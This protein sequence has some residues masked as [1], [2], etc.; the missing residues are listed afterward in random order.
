MSQSINKPP[1]FNGAH[2]SHWK[3]MMM[4]LLQSVDYMLKGFG[5]AILEDKLVRKL[6]YSLP[7]SWDSKKTTIIEAKNLKE[8]K[9]DELIG[10]LLTHELMSKP[11]I[12]EKEKKIKGQGIYINAIALKSS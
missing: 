10:S 8:L 5:E 6:I 7:G 12:R 11:L 2:Y 4:I 1:Y 9:L 3:N